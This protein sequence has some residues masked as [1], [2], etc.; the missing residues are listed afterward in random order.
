LQATK[1]ASTTSETPII[2]LFIFITT[3]IAVWFILQTLLGKKSSRFIRI[4]PDLLTKTIEIIVTTC[5]DK[6]ALSTGCP[7]HPVGRAFLLLP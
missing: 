6:H 7:P 4:N 2:N 1:A 3:S 5:Y